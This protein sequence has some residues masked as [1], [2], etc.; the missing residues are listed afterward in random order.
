MQFDDCVNEIDLKPRAIKIDHEVRGEFDDSESLLASCNTATSEL[1]PHH[2]G[3]F[4]LLAEETAFSISIY[5]ET[6]C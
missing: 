6:S 4:V 3:Q 2:L 1:R 5:A